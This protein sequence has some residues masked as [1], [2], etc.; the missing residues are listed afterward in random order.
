MKMTFIGEDKYNK[1][2][3][4]HSFESSGMT[5]YDILND[6]FK[7]FLLGVGYMFD[8][9]ST[10]DIEEPYKTDDLEKNVL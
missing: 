7:S 6:H 9:C 5:P 2:R 3:V 1:T 10:L 8:P 4:V